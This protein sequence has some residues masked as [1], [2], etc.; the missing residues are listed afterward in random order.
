VI[1]ESP[2]RQAR[3]V[4]WVQQARQVPKDPLD[5][6]DPRGLPE[7]RHNGEAASVGSV[8]RRSAK[9]YRFL[10]SLHGLSEVSG[11]MARRGRPYDEQAAKHSLMKLFDHRRFGSW[12]RDRAKHEAISHPIGYGWIKGEHLYVAHRA[13]LGSMPTTCARA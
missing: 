6:G 5:L 11:E 1:P 12:Y 9:I 3:Q 4:R 2:V 8:K 7:I 10:R 13:T